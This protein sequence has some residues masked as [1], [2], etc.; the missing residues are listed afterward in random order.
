MLGKFHPDMSGHEFDVN[1]STIYSKV[2]LNR[3]HIKG[4]V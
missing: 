3:T 4:C 2:F 1:E